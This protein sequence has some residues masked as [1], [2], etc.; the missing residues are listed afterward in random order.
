MVRTQN[1]HLCGLGSISG[2]GTKILKSGVVW[3]KKLHALAYKLEEAII[4][5][6]IALKMSFSQLCCICWCTVFPWAVIMKG[7]V[8]GNS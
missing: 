4:V 3:P 7:L 8:R 5:F 6:V 2:L 1:F